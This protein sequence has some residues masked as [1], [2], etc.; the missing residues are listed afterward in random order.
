MTLQT[1]LPVLVY[2]VGGS[3]VSAALCQ[4][5]SLTLGP[6]LRS[7]SPLEI[8]AEA[9]FQT[10]YSLGVQAAEDVSRAVSYTHLAAVSQV[11]SF[12]QCHAVEGGPLV[13]C[14]SP[15]RC[16]RVE[17]RILLTQPSVPC[18]QFSGI[19]VRHIA[20]KDDTR[21]GEAGLVDQV[22]AQPG[23]AA[24]PSDHGEHVLSLIHI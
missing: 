21:I 12:R 24:E 11:R 2:D 6:V 5:N 18:G 9:F 7:G 15:R 3:H 10:L 19:A 1:D 23:N 16:E 4:Q 8:S 17:M 22:V 14:D 13:W 20:M